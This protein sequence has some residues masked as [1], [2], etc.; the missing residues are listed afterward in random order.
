MDKDDSDQIKYDESIDTIKE[1]EFKA[2]N[3]EE[4]KI[5]KDASNARFMEVI[6]LL[7]L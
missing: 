7:L 2:S 1:M 4:D 5:N 3:E 6:L